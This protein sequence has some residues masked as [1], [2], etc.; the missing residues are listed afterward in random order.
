MALA[1]IELKYLV[2][3]I[4][5]ETRGYYVSNIYGIDRDSVLFKLHHPD[6]DDILLV[7]STAGVWITSVRIQQIAENRLVRRLRDSLL[8][9]RLEKIEQPGLER[10]AYLTFGGIQEEVR[11]GGRVLR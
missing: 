9:L 1:G 4:S 3:R 2:G 8:R 7:V 5:E 6:R 10:L 11:A